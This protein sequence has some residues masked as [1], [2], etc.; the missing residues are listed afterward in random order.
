MLFWKKPTDE[1]KLAK[2]KQEEAIAALNAGDIPPIARERLELQRKYGGNFFTSDLTAKEY[3]LSREAGYKT[4]GQ[5][6]GTS[7]FRVGLWGQWRMSWDYTTRELSQITQA[8]LDARQYAVKRMTTEAKLLGASGVIG[9]RIESNHHAWSDGVVEFTAFGTAVMVPGYPQEA[10]P[11]ASGLS[12]QEFWLLHEAGYWPCGLAM[13]VCSY[14]IHT[15]SYNRRLVNSSGWFN[16]YANQEVEQYTEGVY[17]A[18][19]LAMKRLTGDLKQM[20]AE[21]AVGMSVKCTLRDVEYELNDVTY[22]DLLVNFIALG[23]AVRQGDHEA[24]PVK[25]LMIYDLATKSY[26]SCEFEM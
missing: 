17:R 23:T 24:T 20:K 26:R 12:G 16:Q 25:P 21:G 15:D 14:Y 5:V 11:F 2:R 18:R 6:M 8:N 1:E 4:L 9:V 7:F 22:H 10:E 3:L 13:G 19:H